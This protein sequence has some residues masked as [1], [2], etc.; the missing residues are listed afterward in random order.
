M[1]TR[2]QPALPDMTV[3]PHSHVGEDSEGNQGFVFT[4]SEPYGNV[5]YAV[6]M[7]LSAGTLLEQPVEIGGGMKFLYSNTGAAFD[8]HWGCNGRGTCILSMYSNQIAARRISSV[9]AANPVPDHHGCFAR[10]QHGQLH[11]DRRGARHHVDQWRVD[12]HVHRR[13]HLHARRPQ[14]YRNLH[15]QQRT[16]GHVR[17]VFKCPKPP[18]TRS[19]A[20]GSGDK[21]RRDSPQ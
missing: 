16:L 3:E 5:A 20:S 11:P 14:L 6:F 4:Y 12:D 10:L 1:N 9:T 18:G 21:A 19:I 7:R 17:S 13:V 2:C 8:N 15:G